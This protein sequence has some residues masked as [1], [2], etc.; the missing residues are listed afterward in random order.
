MGSLGTRSGLSVAMVTVP[1]GKPST[2][3]RKR[4]QHLIS[5]GFDETELNGLFASDDKVCFNSF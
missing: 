2:S 5:Y 1:F 3:V 4:E